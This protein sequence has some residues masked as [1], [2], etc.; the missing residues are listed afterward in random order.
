V[1]MSSRVILAE[2]AV[3]MGLLNEVVAP[4]HLMDRVME[5]ASDM[6][7]NCA[8]TSL[9]AMK[10]QIWGHYDVTFQHA[11]DRSGVLMRTSLTKDD[12]REGVKSY[13]EKRSP[14]FSGLTPDSWPLTT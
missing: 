8:P 6:A 2:E 13:L 4:E 1:L 7:V 9:A 3:T 11:I 5:Y 14:A 10:Q 12:F